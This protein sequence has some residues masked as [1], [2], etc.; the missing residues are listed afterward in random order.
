LPFIDRGEPPPSG[1]PVTP[2]SG[3]RRAASARRRTEFL[4]G[5]IQQAARRIEAGGGELAP[6]SQAY[7]FKLS[8]ASETRPFARI[9]V[10][11][12][13]LDRLAGIIFNATAI[14][15]FV[16]RVPP[17]RPKALT[18]HQSKVKLSGRISRDCCS[19]AQAR[20]RFDSPPI[21]DES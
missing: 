16:S 8:L 7:L 12:P 2:C 15:G 9:S 1:L 5:H 14:A 4:A 21:K 6:A 13:A 17:S 11:R 3:P 20:G 19:F 18:I 10:P